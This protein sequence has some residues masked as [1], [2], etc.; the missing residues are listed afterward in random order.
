M[1]AQ[2]PLEQEI[3]RLIEV[4][5][6]MPVSEFMDLCLSHPQH[7]YYLTRDPFGSEGDFTTAPEISQMFG[8]LIGLWAATVWRSMGSPDTLRLVEL[9]PGRGTLMADALRAARVMPGF[10]AALAVHLVEISPALKR[11]QQQA[12]GTLDIPVSWHEALHEVPGGPT[13][14]IANEFFDA[15]PV[16]QMI[17]RPSGWHERVVELD[18]DGS[19]VW[20]T[21]AEP[22]T[23][24]ERILPKALRQA[25]A[26]ALFEWRSDAVALE[27][28]RRVRSAPGAALVIDYGHARSA[29]GDTLQAVGNHAYRDPLEAPGLVDLTA[30]VDFQALAEAAESLG[31]ALHGPIEQ[32]PFLRNLGIE[33]RA[34][35]L[36]THAKDQAGEIEAGLRRLTDESERG[37]GRM[38]KVLGLADPK[39][40]AVPGFES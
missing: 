2:S 22:T 38:F 8:E 35:V 10:M 4:A 14:I 39:L 33:S 36:K 19:L 30:H 32:A 40:G 23:H 11:Q 16:H 27:L 26:G 29:P 28:G 13:I 25:P 7:G 6:P 24:F 34:A 37:M 3:R 20:G 31:A 18:Q 9:G 17:K 5:G 21:A 15:L 12:L 1:N